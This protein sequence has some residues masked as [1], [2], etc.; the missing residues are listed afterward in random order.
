LLQNV[1]FAKKTILGSSSL[2]NENEQTV[3]TASDHCT[4]THK[5]CCSNS[6]SRVLESEALKDL[7]FTQV[8]Y[9]QQLVKDGITDNGVKTIPCEDGCHKLQITFKTSVDYEAFLCIIIKWLYTGLLDIS[10]ESEENVVENLYKTVLALEIHPLE[11][12]CYRILMHKRRVGNST[13]KQLANTPLPNI[14]EP[15]QLSEI[16]VPLPPVLPN[17]INNHEEV[18]STDGAES[19]P[20]SPSDTT[21]PAPPSLDLFESYISQLKHKNNSVTND[22][23]MCTTGDKTKVDTAKDDSASAYREMWRNA[24][25]DCMTDTVLV[26]EDTPI[27]VHRVVM[28]TRSPVLAA[29]L[30]GNFKEKECSEV[31]LKPEDN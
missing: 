6:S 3:T 18:P 9:K 12:A 5:K 7:P 25:E 16:L 28:V 19:S 2:P 23:S 30:D 8:Q 10:E 11:V 21:P 4:K 15:V 17:I 13:E 22:Q 1:A 27:H 14:H 20:S 29:M 26:V 24:C 31:S